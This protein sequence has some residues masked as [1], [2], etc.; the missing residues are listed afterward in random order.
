MIG[1]IPFVMLATVALG[2][3]DSASV[4]A[5][6]ICSGAVDNPAPAAR[7]QL[8]RSLQEADAARQPARAAFL[9]GCTRFAEK[10]PDKASEEFERAVKLEDSNAMYHYWLARA[11]GEEAENANPLRMPGLARRAKSELERAVALAP[12]FL[13]ARDGLVQFY[14]AAPGIVGGGVDK[15]RAQVAE[16][17]RLD[18][19]RGELA[20]LRVAQHQRDTTAA[21]GGYQALIEAFPDSASAYSQLTLIYQNRRQWADAWRIVDRWNARMPDSYVARYVT[22]RTAAESGERIEAGERAL[23][24]Y[25]A[26]EVKAGEPSIAAAH[27]RL[28]MILEKRG[29]RAAARAEY[30]TALKLDPGLRGAKDG[31]A[32]VK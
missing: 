30:E 20:G 21:I 15:A 1:V 28:G 10:K 22:G 31:L 24:E 7:A 26:H 25:I 3:Q 9:R 5:A 12:N 14:L 27:W 2:A 19:Y 4:S 8:A 6:R 17:R 18:A 13:D 11:V 29:A 23:R 32:R 16:M